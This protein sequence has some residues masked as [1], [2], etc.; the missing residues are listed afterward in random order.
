[1]TDP[2]MAVRRFLAAV[3]QS[4]AQR[5]SPDWIIHAHITHAQRAGET[6]APWTPEGLAQF[7][8]KRGIAIGRFA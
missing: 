5:P 4:L 6:F 7:V 2:H 8:W 1:M 3:E